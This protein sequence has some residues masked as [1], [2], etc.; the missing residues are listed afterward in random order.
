M[1]RGGG[2]QSRDGERA[3]SGS[4]RIGRKGREGKRAEADQSPAELK[5]ADERSRAC[6]SPLSFFYSS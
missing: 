1:L 2:A 3:A 6:V 4:A 5:T